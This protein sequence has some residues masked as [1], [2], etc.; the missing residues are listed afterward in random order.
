MNLC[1]AQKR[2]CFL[3]RWR[4][5]TG[6]R[7]TCFKEFGP[8]S[9]RGKPTVIALLIVSRVEAYTC[10]D[11]QIYPFRGLEEILCESLYSSCLWAASIARL[12]PLP[13]NYAVAKV[14]T[15]HPL[16]NMTRCQSI[17]CF[18]ISVGWITFPQDSF[19]RLDFALGSRHLGP[20]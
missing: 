7:V 19:T 17:A 3:S 5:V 8:R 18:T 4:F 20:L 16:M 13:S 2:I 10:F 12:S 9:D 14:S 6:S 15:A 1:S 11:Y